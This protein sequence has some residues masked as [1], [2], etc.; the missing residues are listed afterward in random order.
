[1]G[2]LFSDLANGKYKLKNSNNN[3]KNVA[4]DKS[5]N[6]LFSDLAK[7]KYT[8]KKN[9]SQVSAPQ[10]IQQNSARSRHQAL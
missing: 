2:D 8:V 4:T 10:T 7:G 3:A 1:M 9:T 6:N 5:S